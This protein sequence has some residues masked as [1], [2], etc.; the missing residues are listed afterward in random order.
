MHNFV[1]VRINLCIT[2]M[3]K[4]AEKFKTSEHK[5]YTQWL[6]MQLK[7]VINDERA[8]SIKITDIAG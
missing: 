2:V 8:E 3:I 7:I 4:Y 1:K 6:K 5:L